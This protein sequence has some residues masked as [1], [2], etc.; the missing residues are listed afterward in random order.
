MYHFFETI[1]ILNGIPQNV[2]YHQLRMDRT[3][4][5]NYSSSQLPLLNEI[6]SV[7]QQYNTNRVKCKIEYTNKL[8]NITFEQYSPRIINSLKL[9]YCDSINY[10]HKYCDRKP[11]NDLLKHRA[12][13]DEI[14]IVKHNKITDTSFSNIA[15]FD[16]ITWYTPAAPLLPGTARARMLNMGILKEMD[17]QPRNLGEF[18]AFVLINSMLDNDLSN[19]ISITSII[20]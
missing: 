16:G 5:L 10:D 7:P 15:F 9:V 8:Y 4:H 12:T 17:I 13:C 20:E 1:N 2:D 14:L 18:K 11:L 6:I 3:L 19:T